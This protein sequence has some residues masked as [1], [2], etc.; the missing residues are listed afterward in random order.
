M[1]PRITL[2]PFRPTKEDEPQEPKD[3]TKQQRYVAP[4]RRRE[5]DVVSHRRREEELKKLKQEAKD[6]TK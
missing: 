6:E 5:E 4:H 3:E 2:G 1:Y